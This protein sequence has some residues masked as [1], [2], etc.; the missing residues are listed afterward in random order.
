[1]FEALSSDSVLNNEDFMR[2]Y[3][4]EPFELVQTKRLLRS[5]EYVPAMG[6]F[7]FETR[8]DR[9]NWATK[10]WS[11]ISQ[12]P[13]PE[14]FTWVVR[15][16]LHE[17]MRRATQP[18]VDYNFLERFWRT[19]SLVVERLDKHLITHSLRALD[20]DVVR[21][22]L[23]HLQ[24]DMPVFRFIL[25]TYAI[26]LSRA[27]VDFWDAMGAISPTSLI[28]MICQN[29]QY[30]HILSEAANAQDE[31][32]EVNDMLSW[33]DP[34]MSSIGLANQPPACRAFA[35]QLMERIQTGQYSAYA[36]MACF[37]IGLQVLVRTLRSFTDEKTSIN[38]SIARLVVFEMMEVVSKYISSILAVAGLS[39]EDDIGRSLA[40]LGMEVI[41][42]TLTLDCQCLK[43]DYDA[44]LAGQRLQHDDTT[45]S[46]SRSIW[47]AVG[48]ALTRNN[49][50]LAEPAL[51]GMMEQVGLER[52]NVEFEVVNVRDKTHFNTAFGHLARA[53][54]RIFEQ[55][56]EFD[57]DKLTT[58]F[59]RSDTASSLIAG[60]LAADQATYEAAT[61]VIKIL[62]SQSGRREAV[63]HLLTTH[64]AATVSCFAWAIQR[65]SQRETFASNPRM[66]KT[67]G[68]V[69]DIL[70]N[71]QAGL[72]RTR[73]LSAPEDVERVASFWMYQWEALTVIFRK[74]EAWAALNDK[75]MM[76]EFCRDTMQF[77]E[78]LFDQYLVF[79]NA[80]GSAIR[81]G[82]A[83]ENK[84]GAEAESRRLLVEY[85]RST[86]NRMV[87]WLKLRDEYL[88]SKS[89]SLV[90]KIL[91][92]LGEWGMTVHPHALEFIANLAIRGTTRSA[93][94]NHEKA[95]LARALEEHQGRRESVAADRGSGR[96]STQGRQAT[97]TSWAKQGPAGGQSASTSSR[98]RSKAGAIDLDKWVSYAKSPR[99]VITIDDF[100]D[101][102]N[103]DLLAA[104]QQLD[105]E[106]KAPSHASRVERVGLK[107]KRTVPP[108][109]EIS[110]QAF[111]EK[112]EREKREKLSRDRAQIAALKRSLPGA[113]ATA[114]QGSGLNGIGVP[115]KDHA[116]P[117]SEMMVSSGSEEDGDDEDDERDG[118]LFG[119]AKP[120]QVSE[121]VQAYRESRL[122]AKR[123]IEQKRP[124]KKVK[125]V[126]NAKDMRARLAP[127]LSALH[128]KILSWDFFFD[129]EF[130]PDSGRKDYTMVTSKFKTP[131][132]YQATFE[133]LHV[134]EAWKGFEK[135]KEET[136]L[137]PFDLKIASRMAVDS[138]VE[139]STSVPV[140]DGKELGLGEADLVLLS[141]A[142][143]PMQD[144][145]EPHCLARVSKINRRKAEMEITYKVNTG[146]PLISS[147]TPNNTL[148]AVKVTSITPLER[149]YGALRGLTYY[150]LCEEII[151]AKP[152]PLLQYSDNQIRPIMEN[153]CVNPAQAKAL[154]SAMDNDAFTL[155]QG[156]PGS[157][158]TKT[159]V[160]IVG[161]LLTGTPADKGIA[162]ARP[163]VPAGA[164]PPP[165]KAPAKKLLVCAPSNAAVDELVMRFKAGAKTLDGLAR[166]LSLVRLGR[167]DAINSAVM[168]V[169]LDELVNQ[170]LNLANGKARNY[171]EEIQKLVEES[172][173]LGD[174]M[175]L[176]RMQLDGA[177]SKGDLAP[178]TER[179]Q[180]DFDLQKRKKHQI[181]MK[182]DEMRDKSNGAQR[183]ADINR[184]KVQQEIL[185][186]A[187]VICATLSGSG[188]DM[189]QNL[190]IEFETVI[191]DEAAQSV[192]LSA[193]IPLKYGCSKC[194]L[195][196]DPK[197]LPPTVISRE[198]ARFQYE[199]SL[200]VR[201]QINHPDDVHLLDTQYRMHPEISRF[202]S[203]AF[204]DGRLLDGG[205]MAQLRRQPWHASVLLSP[206]RFFDVQG[207]HQRASQGHS[208]INVAEL[209]VA[210]QLYKRLTTDFGRYDYQ[211][212]V[213]IITPYKSQLKELKVRFVQQYGEG[214]F[215]KIEFNTTDA[216]Q[217]RESEI[218]IFSCVRA[219]PKGG[220]GF[221]DDIRRMNV[222]LTRAKSSL[223]V[224]GNSQSLVQNEFWR[225]LVEDARERN[226]YTGGDVMALLARP[227]AKADLD[228]EMVDAPLSNEPD[229][230]I[231]AT[232]KTR[233]TPPSEDGSNSKSQVARRKDD[234][235][236]KREPSPPVRL[237]MIKPGVSCRRPVG[238]CTRLTILGSSYAIVKASTSEART[239]S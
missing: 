211:R 168:D 128:E 125:Q 164:R 66:L 185:D 172:R 50:A 105:R 227:L 180:R 101:P 132:D 230:K 138:F 28:E 91:I 78:K 39:Q 32:S 2:Q 85:P 130:P 98:E 127:N 134:L 117:K 46:S 18:G 70:C 107:S 136:N 229:P 206:Y 183:D 174:A 112:R 79:A 68:D 106:R 123:Q 233:N 14:E 129:G 187:D 216:F 15:D 71:S 163:Q 121:N 141:K 60:L 191:I 13:T 74:T 100:G 8:Q 142:R 213:G 93:L 179:L 205:D 202:P 239:H 22:G 86:M 219:S 160:A 30:T 166:K 140:K 73:P 81:T 58:L 212:K 135:C 151:K 144:P 238:F 193:L 54:S 21:L 162:I 124:V 157:G 175:S 148:R 67:S 198:A 189:F 49:V 111:R 103:D 149:E 150:D 90:C 44:L 36:R 156:P 104:S 109:N 42:R 25:H 218:I 235:K 195:V 82:E 217:G 204:Y 47:D 192:E 118:E 40:P 158:K 147:M 20:I 153:Y 37:Q 102:P 4:D 145:K 224:L 122:R 55:L 199:Q 23:D 161:A 45:S 116:P 34:F 223:W 113:R 94:Q 89:V 137:K 80:I 19:V 188:H 88:A 16:P 232:Q 75:D 33:I 43:I 114:D 38:D 61:D 97:L 186:N 133:P 190:S 154:K 131:A 171:G 184:R 146:N 59:Q 214:I 31:N 170:K 64:F 77:A 126:R 115:G 177:R 57:P 182:L 63:L 178:E 173:A 215:E 83:S 69:L 236:R 208:L 27:P 10:C 52:F 176:S 108:V 120:S 87:H 165:P 210:L 167:S 181:G 152:S 7:L 209:T 56:S 119:I 96:L 3:F 234:P 228:V 62:S 48:N 226:R 5:R 155:V 76:K 110:A 221:L 35:A 207:L 72:L 29:P 17:A 1:M 194:I 203:K 24:V 143:S 196:G 237:P 159:I 169:T 200:F 201:M 222:G 6:R 139:L 41:R 95:E 65:I 231:P 99:D 51:T 220:I 12:S 92:R 225:G 26:I 53:V 11:K 9:V 84:A 197:Q